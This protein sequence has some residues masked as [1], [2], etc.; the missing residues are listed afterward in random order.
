M[1]D[2]N[3][4]YSFDKYVVGASNEYAVVC[5]RSIV[6]ELGGLYNP[7]FIYGESGTGK[8]H[9]MNAIGLSIYEQKPFMNVV[10]ITAKQ[11][12]EETI[13]CIRNGSLA[14]MHR[15]YDSIDVLMI[16]GMEYLAGKEATQ[17]EFFDIFD[18]LYHKG[19]QIILSS[20]TEPRKTQGITRRLLYRFERGIV[21]DLA[22]PDDEV[23]TGILEQILMK[24]DF[25]ISADLK[26]YIVKSTSNGFEIEGLVKKLY[27]HYESNGTPGGVMTTECAK[28]ILEKGMLGKKYLP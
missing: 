21:V 12:T 7:L 25:I 5:A 14:E 22:L 28:E 4:E 20:E 11:F 10:Y 9:L 13:A 27:M 8:T 16:D 2:L 18:C 17:E 6:D 1:S 3:I 24:F 19:I 26:D 15:K 23:K